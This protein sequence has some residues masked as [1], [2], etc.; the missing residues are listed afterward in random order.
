MK[1]KE[2]FWLIGTT[3]FVLILNF[4]LFGIDMFK[5]G[6]MVDLNIHD[7]YFIISKTHVVLIISLCIFFNVYLIR[8][9]RRNFKNLSA[10]LIF[11]SIGLLSIWMLTGVTSMV[12]GY[13]EVTKTT[14]YN[15][16][17]TTNAFEV[18][19]TI[20]YIYQLIVVALIVLCGFKTGINYKQT[21]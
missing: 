8:M 9:L 12:S 1:Q 17:I 6:L 13:I 2:F 4:I 10:N 16:N 20:L 11:I 5:P 14:D 19:A 21:T 3:G 15:L 7:T 18:A